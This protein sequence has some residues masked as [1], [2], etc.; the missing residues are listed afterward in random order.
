MPVTIRRLLSVESLGL[1][2]LAG[3]TATERAVSWVHGSEVPDPAPWLTGGEL[4]LTTGVRL[5]EPGAMEAFCARLAEA[6]AAGIG[7]AVGVAFEEAPEELITA[8]SRH[9]LVLLQVPY[10]TPFVAIAKELAGA[11]AA[12]EHAALRGALR[13]QHRL[14]T[15]ALSEGG[16]SGVLT[17]LAELLD[18]WCV[19]ADAELRVLAA[20]PERAASRLAEFGGELD[21]LRRGELDTVALRGPEEHILGHRLGADPHDGRG[22]LLVGTAHRHGTAE[23]AMLG[24][25]V[26]L[27]GLGLEQQR[28]AEQAAHRARNDLVVQLLYDRVEPGLAERRLA[29]WGLAAEK[30]TVAALEGS[31]GA[32]RFAADGVLACEHEDHVFLLGERLTPVLGEHRAGL[33]APSSLGALDFARRSAIQALRIGAAEGRR[34]TRTE[35][36]HG[37]R[38]LLRLHEEQGL[39]VFVAHVLGP[40]ESDAVLL[41]S[42][43]VFLDHNGSWHQAANRLGVHRHTLRA[44]L[45][46]AQQRLGRSLDSPYTRMELGLALHGRELLTPEAAQRHA[47]DQSG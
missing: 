15:A 35:D 38:L 11:L 17:E 10:R 34:I 30:L 19:L 22:V 8:A 13:S 14:L 32:E 29:E 4:L 33:S 7:F 45:D 21:R 37:M 1:E 46:R 12:E 28:S 26:S 18:G 44:R 23:H 42:L 5:T 16:V 43:R 2:V 40:L 47:P 20:A 3:H 25:A 9:G 6:G 39:D 31:L 24:A 41:E 27:L 36:L